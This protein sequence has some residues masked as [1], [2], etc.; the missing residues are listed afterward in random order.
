MC[1]RK[2][3]NSMDPY[4]VAVIK[5]LEFSGS[6]P[7]TSSRSSAGSSGTVVGHVPRKI[8]AACN[9]FLQKNGD[10]GMTCT[11]TGNRHHSRNSRFG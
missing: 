9:I 5:Q 4:A 6:G 11:I 2:P 8:L 10:A 3:S 1:E 7:A